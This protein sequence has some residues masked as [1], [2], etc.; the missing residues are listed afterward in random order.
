M[1]MMMM[2]E[3]VGNGLEQVTYNPIRLHSQ[4]SDKKSKCRE[5]LG[6]AFHLT[7]G[8][9]CGFLSCL[10]WVFCFLVWPLQNLILL[11]YPCA[12]YPPKAFLDGFAVSTSCPDPFFF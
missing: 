11:S 12:L 4:Y 7:P 1:A 9:K 3:N 10:C 6:G 5:E 8:H 2:M